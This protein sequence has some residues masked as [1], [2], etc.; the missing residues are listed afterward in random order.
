MKERL[1]GLLA[2]ALGAVLITTGI[3]TSSAG[4]VGGIAPTCAPA[5]GAQA[6]CPT[7]TIVVK[8]T[9][10]PTPGAG[11]P[12]PPANWTVTITSTCID[13]NTGSAVNQTVSVP[14]N[15]QAS[16]GQLYVFQTEANVTPCQYNYTQTK[17]TGFTTTYDTT[18]PFIIPNDF[19]AD[20]ST[21]TVGVVNTFPRSTPTSTTAAPTSVTPS[22]SA[23]VLAETGPKTRIT[24]SVYIGIGL[25]LLGAV[26]LF[27]GSRRRNGKRV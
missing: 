9:T 2:V 19:G 8:E 1:G 21:V 17:V 15:G 20:T 22:S 26:M 13:P 27:G 25:V 11:D 16:S 3:N 10:T 6:P 14:N 4:Q 18:N 5:A 7:G 23:P 12:T 24:A